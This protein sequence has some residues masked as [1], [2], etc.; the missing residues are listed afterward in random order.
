MG[1]IRACL[2]LLAA[3]GAL[4]GTLFRTYSSTYLP[5]KGRVRRVRTKVRKQRVRNGI[6]V[7]HAGRLAELVVPDLIG[8][9]N[10]DKMIQLGKEIERP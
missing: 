8:M 3:G 4:S 5:A 7:K 6:P 2:E 1:K 10:P 9:F